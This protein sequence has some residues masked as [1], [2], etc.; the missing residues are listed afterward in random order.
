M[1][2]QVIENWTRLR[3][4]VMRIAPSAANAGYRSVAIRVEAACDVPS[5]PN[6]L[7]DTVGSVVEVQ[8]S[9]A[10]AERLDLLPGDGVTGLVR[11]GGPQ[12]Y[13]AH[14]EE[15]SSQHPPRT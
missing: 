5:F 9:G 2:V 7:R 14:V 3:G 12:R 11:M 10:A 6:L 15:F 8:V 1:R 4:T 13:F